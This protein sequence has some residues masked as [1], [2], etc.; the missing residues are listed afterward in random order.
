M[1]DCHPSVPPAFQYNRSVQA[2]DTVIVGAGVIG[3]S[4]A[5]R[6]RQEGRRVLIIDKG[7]PGREA[8]YA[9]GGMIAHCDPHLPASLRPLALASAAM[10][11]EFA[12]QLQDEAGE[13]LDLRGQGALAFFAEDEPLNCEDSR[14]LDALEIARLEPALVH[15]PL[16]QGMRAYWLSERSVDPRKLCS[17]LV[18]AARHRGVDFVTGS[19]VT[20]VDVQ[21]G[22][23]AGVKTAHSKYAAGV[24]VNCAGAWASQIQPLGLPTRPAKGQMVCVIPAPDD[25]SE[26]PL[27]QHVV[28]TPDIYIIPRSDRRILLGATV[29]DAGFDKRTDA[30]TIEKLYRAAVSAV[31]KIGGMRIHDA[32]AGLRPASPDGLPMLGETSLPGYFA[33]TGHY[34]DGIM[35]APITAEVMTAIILGQE[36]PF[37]LRPFSP[38]RF[39]V[40][41]SGRVST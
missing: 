36:T 7:E 1:S 27:V 34:R 22:R 5:R 10:Y 37:D 17:A 8:S 13:S 26:G 29:E 41:G 2:W 4:L 14:G 40:H 35:L 38:R 32:W 11:P 28:R 3:L 25:S 12:R 31:P 20:E 30:E 33:A 19:A 23:A 39:D 18:K 16:T 24:V 6:L 9:A 21:N 15:P